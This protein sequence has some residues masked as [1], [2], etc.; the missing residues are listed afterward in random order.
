MFSLVNQSNILFLFLL[1]LIV[2]LSTIL[3]IILY[4]TT[5]SGIKLNRRLNSLVFTVDESSLYEAI[6]SVFKFVTDFI[7]SYY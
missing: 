3:L 4:F 7:D 6:L 1:L 5:A 2:L